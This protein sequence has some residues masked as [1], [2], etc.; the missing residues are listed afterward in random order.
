M[1]QGP[2]E[3]EASAPPPEQAPDQPSGTSERWATRLGIASLVCALIFPAEFCVGLL[4]LAIGVPWNG[5]PGAREAMAM[6]LTM[7]SLFAVVFGIFS[8]TGGVRGTALIGTIVGAVEL[9]LCLGLA[10]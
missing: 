8:L 2:G 7:S 4:A 9:Y 5:P 6:F 1:T 3:K 10:H